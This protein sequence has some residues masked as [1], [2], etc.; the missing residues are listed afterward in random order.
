[1]L[2]RLSVRGRGKKFYLFST[3][4][5]LVLG[6]T[7]S[8]IQWSPGA[9]SVGVKRQRREVNH[10]PPSSAELRNDGAIPPSPIRLNGIVLNN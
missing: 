4:S 6:P 2:I 10:S 9:F 5:R 8:P 3:A 1:M 7:Q